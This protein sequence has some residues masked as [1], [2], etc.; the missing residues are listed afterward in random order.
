MFT[1]RTKA[2]ILGT[3]VVV[4]VSSL[5]AGLFAVAAYNSPEAAYTPI[6]AYGGYALLNAT[7]FW[8]MMMRTWNSRNHGRS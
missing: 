3:G 2:R 5:W 1:S 6:A 7:M 8:T 4:I